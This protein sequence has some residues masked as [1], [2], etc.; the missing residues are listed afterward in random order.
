MF[1]SPDGENVFI[2]TATADLPGPILM[3]NCKYPKAST[4][5]K[6]ETKSCTHN[7]RHTEFTQVRRG[8]EAPSSIM[9]CTKC[10]EQKIC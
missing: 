9:E 3:L 2:S 1:F 10:H 8:D 7:F 5:Q 4:G 6:Y